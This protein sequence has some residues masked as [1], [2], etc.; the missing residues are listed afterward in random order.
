MEQDEPNNAERNLDWE[1]LRE[2]LKTM[3]WPSVYM[4]KFIV[5]ADNQK[6]AQVENL[7]NTHEAQI[8]LRTSSKGNYISITARELMLSAESVIERYQQ[9]GSIDGLISL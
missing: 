6:V 1:G 7:F 4:F 5:P 3:A 8:E 2:K 9:A